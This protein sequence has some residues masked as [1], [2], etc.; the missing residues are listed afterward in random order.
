M[1]FLLP[2]LGLCALFASSRALSAEPA[3][4]GP[5]EAEIKTALLS[6]PWGYEDVPPN[7]WKKAWT[8]LQFNPDGTATC[9]H[10]ATKVKSVPWQITGPKTV[11]SRISGTISTMA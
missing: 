3:W 2:F 8:R 11:K 1:K 4:F 5:S 7:P 9:Y 6:A 10:Y